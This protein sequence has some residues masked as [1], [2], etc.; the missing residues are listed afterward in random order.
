MVPKD[1]LPELEKRFDKAMA[2]KNYDVNIVQAGREYVSLNM[3]KVK[4]GMFMVMLLKE[5]V[6]I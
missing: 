6:C 5:K 4:R 1:R 2:M 3:P